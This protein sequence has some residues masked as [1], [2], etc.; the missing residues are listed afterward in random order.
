M[1]FLTD[2]IHFLKEFY[3]KSD[4]KCLYLNIFFY[5]SYCFYLCKTG[6]RKNIIEW[7]SLG[8]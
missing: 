8:L 4:K 3:E 6:I 5:G 7:K 1:S 2:I